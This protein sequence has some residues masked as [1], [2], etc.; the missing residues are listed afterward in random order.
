MPTASEV[1][2]AETV[3]ERLRVRSCTVASTPFQN[4]GDTIVLVGGSQTVELAATVMDSIC[5]VSRGDAI[6]EQSS[7]RAGC[8][9]YAALVAAAVNTPVAAG[10][11]T[12]LTPASSEPATVHP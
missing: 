9:E 11:S 8:V 6:S 1:A 2:V 12:L 3:N 5:L 10:T 4:K 7:G